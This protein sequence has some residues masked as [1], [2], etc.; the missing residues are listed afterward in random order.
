MTFRP[1]PW[2][3]VNRMF[4]YPPSFICFVFSVV[5]FSL[6]PT[7]FF[8]HPELH[9][10]RWIFPSLPLVYLL[11]FG[12]ALFRDA[13]CNNARV[14]GNLLI[15]SFISVFGL[16]KRTETIIDLA[17]IQKIIRKKEAQKIGNGRFIFLSLIFESKKQKQE[18]ISMRTWDRKNFAQLLDYL[19]REFPSIKFE[20]GGTKRK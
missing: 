11:L 18:T 16:G 2:P 5:I 13:F 1:S 3:V 8:L 4:V 9:L 14:E 7:D 12:I 6:I 10:N 15:I 19:S 20:D 17:K